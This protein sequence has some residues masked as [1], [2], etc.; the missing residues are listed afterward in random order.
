MLVSPPNSY[1]EALNPNLTIFGDR[2][3]TEVIKVK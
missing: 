2:D 3:F 1:V